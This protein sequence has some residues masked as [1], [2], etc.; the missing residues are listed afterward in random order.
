M[1]G[2]LQWR[3][4]GRGPGLPL[5]LDQTEAR[6]TENNF[7]RDRPPTPPP[8]A[9]PPPPLIS[10]SGSGTDLFEWKIYERATFL[11]KIVCKGVTDWTSRSGAFLYQKVANHNDCGV[12]LLLCSPYTPF[13]WIIVLLKL[14]S[15]TKLSFSPCKTIWIS[16]SAKFCGIRTAGNFCL[17]NVRNPGLSESII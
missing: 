9:P 16:E 10:R 4:H 13:N 11:S 6:R 3:I 8:P 14:F 17:W 15:R 5:F 1:K 7:F 2:H 12:V